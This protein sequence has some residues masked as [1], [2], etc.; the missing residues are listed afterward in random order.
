MISIQIDSLESIFFKMTF[1]LCNDDDDD[2][3]DSDN[4]ESIFSLTLMYSIGQ[5]AVASIPPAIQPADMAKK[6]FFFFGLVSAIVP[7]NAVDE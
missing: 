4:R 2:D 7:V 3:D 1:E 5:T 6:G